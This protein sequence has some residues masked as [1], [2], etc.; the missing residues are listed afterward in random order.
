M[1]GLRF[2]QNIWKEEMNDDISAANA[3]GDLM[4]VL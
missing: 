4:E 2:R 3:A 1:Q